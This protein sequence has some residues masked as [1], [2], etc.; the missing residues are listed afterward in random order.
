MFLVK[1]NVDN[2][3]KNSWV[4]MSLEVIRAYR[5]NEAHL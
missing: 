5:M 4:T 2:L 1:M 3:W